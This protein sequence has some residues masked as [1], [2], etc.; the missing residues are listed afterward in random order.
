MLDSAAVFVCAKGGPIWNFARFPRDNGDEV[1][2]GRDNTYLSGVQKG[3]E[4]FAESVCSVPRMKF[5][6]V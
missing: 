2:R 1:V 5:C 4:K 3:C 6:W